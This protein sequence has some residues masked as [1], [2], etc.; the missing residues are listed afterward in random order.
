MPYSD[1]IDNRNVKLRG[2]I[3]SILGS[4]EK[5]KFAVGYIYLSGFYQIVKILK[6]N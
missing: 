5:V 4:S 1:I 6:T 3:N 2:E